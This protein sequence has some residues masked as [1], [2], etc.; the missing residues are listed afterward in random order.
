[1]ARLRVFPSVATCLL[2]LGCASA[3]VAD[4]PPAVPAMEPGVKGEIA[5]VRPYGYV[6]Y[7][8]DWS[9]TCI[10]AGL[11][12]V[13]RCAYWLQ[14]DGTWASRA[15]SLTVKGSRL[16]G[17]RGQIDLTLTRL[18]DGFSVTGIYWMEDVDL[19]VTSKGAQARRFRYVRDEKGAYASVDLPGNFVLLLGEAARI[20]DPKWPQFALA[21]VV[22]GWG[23][24]IWTQPS[25][26]IPVPPD[27]T[28][29]VSPAWVP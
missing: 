19:V 16:T 23:V 7:Q 2:L 12:G 17:A 24:H 1:M 26:A 14:A 20:E 27:F 22:A 9:D 11:R 3:P 13:S 21:A 29:N 4:A 5:W 10:G 25:N 15:T 18:P 6:S 28:R 8:A